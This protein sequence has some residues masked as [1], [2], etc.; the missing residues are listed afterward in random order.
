MFLPSDHPCLT[1]VHKDGL[2]PSQAPPTTVSPL[3]LL[4]YGVVQDTD[5]EVPISSSRR[6][7]QIP[8]PADQAR[9][10]VSPIRTLQHVSH[11]CTWGKPWC[12]PRD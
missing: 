1:A 10:H 2:E 4:S 9:S 7:V 6:E 5:Y 12:E 8:Y 11:L 3:Q